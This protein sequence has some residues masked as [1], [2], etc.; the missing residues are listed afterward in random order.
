MAN[1]SERGCKSSPVHRFINP[2]NIQRFFEEAKI[3]N[4]IGKIK[5]LLNILAQNIHCGS[6]LGPPRLAVLTSIHNVCFGSKIRKLGIPLQTPSFL[7]K[8]GVKGGIHFMD[9]LS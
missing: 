8:S 1:S 2:F 3:E 7:C 6:A 4:Y 5:I 9:M